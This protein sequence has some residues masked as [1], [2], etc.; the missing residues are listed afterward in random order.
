MVN[1]PYNKKK[2]G[3]DTDNILLENRIVF[4]Y[5]D[6][7]DELAL[8]INKELMALDIISHKPIT[9]ILNT[10]GG[11]CSAGISIIDTIKRTS[12]PIITFINGGVCSMG[13]HIALSGDIRWAT[14]ISTWM[15][16]DMSDY[17]WDTVQKLEDRAKFMKKYSQIFIDQ[18]KEKTNLTSKELRKAKNG[19]LWFIGEEL[20]EKGIVDE[21]V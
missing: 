13:V 5:D 8:N 20:K 3:I 19:E 6:I 21:I 1:K 9:V 14:N 10:N 2:K 7:T 4:I 16:H 15:N 11:S 17:I 12:S 18:M